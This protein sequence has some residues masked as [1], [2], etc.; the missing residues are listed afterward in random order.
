MKGNTNQF[1]S[2]ETR[3]QKAAKRFFKKALRP[4]HVLKLLV[5][6]DR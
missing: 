4:F 3:N 1:S 2:S 5:I 6:T